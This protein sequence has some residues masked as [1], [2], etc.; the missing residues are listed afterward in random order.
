MK[1]IAAILLV[2]LFSTTVFAMGTIWFHGSL[3]D[4]KAKA[5]S[6]NKLLLI[7]FYAFG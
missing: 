6:E 2:I 1:K 5:V 3:D 4:A 7:D